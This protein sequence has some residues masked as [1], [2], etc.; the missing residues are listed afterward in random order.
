MVMF[1]GCLFPLSICSGEIASSGIL[2]FSE[3]SSVKLADKLVLPLGES[4][5]PSFAKTLVIQNFNHFD[6]LAGATRYKLPTGMA[7]LVALRSKGFTVGPGDPD[8]H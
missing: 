3:A 4:V 5:S 7:H 6:K 2:K 8:R 1:L